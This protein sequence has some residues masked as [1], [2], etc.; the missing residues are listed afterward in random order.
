MK[1][2]IRRRNDSQKDEKN[3]HPGGAAGGGGGVG[4]GGTHH[5]PHAASHV[6][7]SMTQQRLKLWSSRENGHTAQ[8]KL[9]KPE[10][11]TQNQKEIN[12]S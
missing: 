9:A 8:M 2:T 5:H 7:G 6:T 10:K 4:K 1:R 3:D 11:K 12:A